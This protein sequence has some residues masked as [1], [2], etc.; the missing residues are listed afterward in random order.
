VRATLI[1][2][3]EIT[4]DAGGNFSDAGGLDGAGEGD[5]NRASL[6]GCTDAVEVDLDGVSLFEFGSTRRGRA[7]E[8]GLRL[9][10]GRGVLDGFG[11]EEV[12]VGREDHSSEAAFGRVDEGL[13]YEGVVS[14]EVCEG[15]EGGE[16]VADAKEEVSVAEAP[17]VLS[18]VVEVP[19]GAR[20]DFTSGDFQ[21]KGVDQTVLIVSWL[22]RQAGDKAMDDEGNEEVLVINVVH[23]KHGA[24]VEHKLSGERLEA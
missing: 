6:V 1:H 12:G 22:V 18:G 7:K 2:N 16:S 5:W 8:R 24:A 4:C 23:G 15:S 14:R 13:L 20:E 17:E 3:S 21:Q 19:G 9:R 10:L 11:D